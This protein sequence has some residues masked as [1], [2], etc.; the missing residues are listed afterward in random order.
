MCVSKH[1]SEKRLTWRD[2]DVC[3]VFVTH[4]ECDFDVGFV[5]V[6]HLVCNFV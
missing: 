2:F 5:F 4:L 1:T 3:F 6:T